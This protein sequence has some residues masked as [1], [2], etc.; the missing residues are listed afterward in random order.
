MYSEQRKVL[1]QLQMPNLLTRESKASG[2]A[3]FAEIEAW[4]GMRE[5]SICSGRSF[6]FLSAMMGT[7]AQTTMGFMASNPVE[8]DAYGTLGFDVFWM[9]ITREI[10]S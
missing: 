4:R 6:G 7:V 10:N 3:S 9:E 8:A 5:N 1:R 2:S